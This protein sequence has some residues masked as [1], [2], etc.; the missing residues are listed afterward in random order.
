MRPLRLLALPA[1]AATLIFGAACATSSSDP[2][3]PR[4]D[5]NHVPEEVA[6]HPGFNAQKA[7]SINAPREDKSA[8]PLC[9]RKCPDGQTCEVV[10][11]VEKCVAR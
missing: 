9:A 5:P 4:Q 10:Q 11:G 6:K 7:K 8:Q 2:M 1:L 3:P